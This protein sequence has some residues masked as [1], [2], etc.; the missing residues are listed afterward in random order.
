M[1]RV[2][3][4]L[5]VA[6]FAGAF[7][8]FAENPL[9]KRKGLWGTCVDEKG[10][11]VVGVSVLLGRKPDLSDA[12]EVKTT[13]RGF[14][15]P[16]VSDDVGEFRIGIRSDEWFIRTFH[17][18]TRR[19]SGEIFQ[20]DSG[21]L[22]PGMQDRMPPVHFRTGNVF[23][24]FTLVRLSE[25]PAPAPA[26]PAVPKEPTLE[27]KV[28]DLA[29]L[30]DYG[31]AA[32][33]LS[34]AIEA[35]P[36][37]PDLLWQRALLLARASRTA[38]ALADA[39]KV[40]RLDAQRKGVRLQM[41]AWLAEIGK[42]NEAL[43][44]LEQE[45][46]I[47]PANPVVYGGLAR[48]YARLERKDESEQAAARWIELA[49]DDSEALLTL[50]SA[51]SAKGD[52]AAAEKLYRRVAEKDPDSAYRTFYNLGAAIRNQGG[53]PEAAIA[54]FRRAIDLKPDYARAHRE[55]GYC[56]LGAGKTAEAVAEFERYLALAADDPEAPDVR[57]L[58]KTLKK[59]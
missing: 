52:F 58:L 36:D 46:A 22:G 41:A 19:P 25:A 47:D 33:A 13:A 16:F 49:P 28:Q 37:D 42:E 18:K 40:V 6:L 7:A 20:D 8:A 34:T 27:Q 31:G 54:A 11:P 39:R 48:A 5:F 57:E 43:G 15:F 32:D 12:Q 3:A 30:G 45:R 51:K 21:Q 55:L 26:R 17:I 38:D 29:A 10:Q 53:D 1:R 59:R 50:A 14:V 4:L 35:K 44:L 56:L 23:V 2:L 9:E 24:E